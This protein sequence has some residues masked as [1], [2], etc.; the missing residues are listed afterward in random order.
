MFME[1][2]SNYS[3]SKKSI[4]IGMEKQIGMLMIE[5]WDN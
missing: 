3:D 2:V 5:L 4:Y 1:T